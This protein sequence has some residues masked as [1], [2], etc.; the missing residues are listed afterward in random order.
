MEIICDLCDQEYKISYHPEQYKIYVS[1]HWCNKMEISFY[2]RVCTSCD[3]LIRCRRDGFECSEA[4]ET[5]KDF[6]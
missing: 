3:S 6:Y 4:L 1:P 5:L 2:D